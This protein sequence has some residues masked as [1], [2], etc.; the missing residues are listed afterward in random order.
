MRH[1]CHCFFALALRQPRSRPK[2]DFL[3]SPE[4]QK[5]ALRHALRVQHIAVD[6]WQALVVV[7]VEV[8]RSQ[9]DKLTRTKEK[10]HSHTHS[11]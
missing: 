11:C 6:A 8:V 7:V 3:V 4:P 10:I 2:K 1:R 5:H 9:R